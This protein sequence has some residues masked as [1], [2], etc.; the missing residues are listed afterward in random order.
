MYV[1][2]EFEIQNQNKSGGARA[3]DTRLS[4]NWAFLRG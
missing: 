1:F 3:M 4:N 2:C